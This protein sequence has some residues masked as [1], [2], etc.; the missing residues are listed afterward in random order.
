MSMCLAMEHD[1]CVL[2]PRFVGKSSWCTVRNLETSP[3]SAIGANMV[4]VGSA[5]I[6]L[7]HAAKKYAGWR[8]YERL[9]YI[10]G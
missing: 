4:A 7:S 8:F 1:A 3:V 2:L 5:R 6:R 9:T 10:A